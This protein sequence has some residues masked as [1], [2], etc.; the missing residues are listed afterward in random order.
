MICEA[1]EFR[2]DECPHV[3]LQGFQAEPYEISQPSFVERV[4]E[5]LERYAI[6]PGDDVQS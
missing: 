6:A 5:F 3:A 1:G 2:D 4:C